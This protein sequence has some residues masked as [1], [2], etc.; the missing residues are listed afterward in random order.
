MQPVRRL[1]Q[2]MRFWMVNSTTRFARFVHLAITPDTQLY[3]WYKNILNGVEDRRNGAIVLMD[4]RHKQ[5]LR[6]EFESGWICK[7]EGP[8]LNATS[9][10]VVIESL[11]I[12]VERVELR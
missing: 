2:P 9:N 12:C 11:E 3:G 8:M 4:E 10:D 7:W 5:V 6:W 1:R